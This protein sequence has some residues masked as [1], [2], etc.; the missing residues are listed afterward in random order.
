[1]KMNGNKKYWIRKRARGILMTY[2]NE[3]DYQTSADPMKYYFSAVKYILIY[4]K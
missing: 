2:Y 4:G 1:M 3:L